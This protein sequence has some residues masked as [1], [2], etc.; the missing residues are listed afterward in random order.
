MREHRLDLG[1]EGQPAV[2][3]RVVDERLFAQPIARQQQQ[4]PPAVPQRHGEHAPQPL[5]TLD[6]V[7]LVRVDDDFGVGLRRKPMP[8][9]FEVLAQLEEVVDLAVVDDADAAVLVVDRLV[10]ARRR[11]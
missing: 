2:R 4:V 11:R 7:L 5:D 10:A 8:A 6:A 9:A 1:R 3:I